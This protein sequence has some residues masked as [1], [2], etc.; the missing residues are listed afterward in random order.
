MA[1]PCSFQS[2]P[3]DS[4]QQ[5]LKFFSVVFLYTHLY[6]F[7]CMPLN[8]VAILYKDLPY[9]LRKYY[10]VPSSLSLHAL[11]CSFQTLALLYPARSL[12]FSRVQLS[13]L[14]HSQPS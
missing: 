11:L 13:D 8:N 9:L 5:C 4:Y 7:I 1:E 10:P 14:A 2:R 6:F 12:L 3:F